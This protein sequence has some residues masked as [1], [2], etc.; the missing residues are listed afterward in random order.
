[1]LALYRSGRQAEA[2]EVYR[3]GRRRLANDLGLEPGSELQRLER[4]ILEQDP[5]LDA[6]TGARAPPGASSSPRRAPGR[7]V[8]MGLVLVV[9]AVAG[10]TV[11]YLAVRDDAAASVTIVPP[12]LV[13]V[14]PA[15][16]R[17]VAAI[18]V[19]SRPAAV[20]AGVDAV[21]VGDARD[22]T[23]TRIDPETR[24]VVKT[25][26]IGSPVVDLAAGMGSLWAATGG[27]GEVV[28]IDPEVGAVA[29]RIPL[30]DPDDP[31]VP[32]VSA[33][34]VGDGRVWAGTVEGLAQIDPGAGAIVRTVDLDG[35]VL[36]IAVGDGA[37]WSTTLAS[38]AMRIEA[39]SARETVAVLRRELGVSDRSR[40]RR[41]LDRRRRRPLEGRP[42]HGGGAVLLTSD[43]GRVRYRLR[44]RLGLGLVRCQVRARAPESRDG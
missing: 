36:Q 2:L 44:R 23:V 18:P 34:G 38:R 1:M 32:S 9:A 16:N 28:Q 35:G 3:D 10:I 17:V 33:I 27:F 39:S 31:F 40:R 13:V 25:I 4:A 30:G 5:E 8:A 21:W 7:R 37:V 43:A 20:S 15:T 12:A 41:R 26:G 42:G 11:G 6:P 24:R 14:D 22:G 29:R 19:G